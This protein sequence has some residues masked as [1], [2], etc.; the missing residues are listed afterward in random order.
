MEQGDLFWAYPECSERVFGEVRWGQE[1]FL[2]L[3]RL[4][5]GFGGQEYNF[6]PIQGSEVDLGARGPILGLSRLFGAGLGGA[7]DLFGPIYG[8]WSKFGG[9]GPILGLSRLFGAGFWWGQEA[10]FG[11]SSLFAGFEGQ[12]SNF[13]PIQ[14]SGAG[15]AVQEAYFGLPD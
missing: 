2:G 9:Q 13:G 6:G 8:V 3:S 10:F 14:G 11:L 1:A 4:F 5:G 15:F 12:V 7:G